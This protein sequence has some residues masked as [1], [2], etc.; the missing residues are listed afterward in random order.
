MGEWAALGESVPTT[1]IETIR[2]NMETLIHALTPTSHAQVKFRVERG[3]VPFREWCQANPTASFRRYAIEQTGR[4]EPGEVTNL[5][6]EEVRTELEIMVAYPKEWGRYGPQN[7]QDLRDTLDADAMQLRN[8]VGHKGNADWVAGQ[9][10]A[11]DSH[12]F[13]DGSPVAFL[14]ITLDTA[15][16]RSMA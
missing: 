5:D 14:V 8:A 15:Y 9:H 2:E 13:E 12:V 16:Y 11:R 7:I 10:D 3:E 6:I 1:T 4:S